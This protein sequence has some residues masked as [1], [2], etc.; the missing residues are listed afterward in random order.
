MSKG[1]YPRKPRAAKPPCACGKPFVARGKCRACYSKEWMTRVSPEKLAARRAGDAAR[2]RAWYRGLS[3]EERRMVVRR[4]RLRRYQLTQEDF[5]SM[6]ER[7]GGTCA[8]C[9]RSPPKGKVLHVDHDHETGQTRGLLCFRC[10]TDLAVIENREWASAA[11]DYLRGGGFCHPVKTA[12][13]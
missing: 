7:Q 12:A 6:V 8:I 9:H 4:V 2:T 13:A 11:L 10:N 1:V 5:D 3:E